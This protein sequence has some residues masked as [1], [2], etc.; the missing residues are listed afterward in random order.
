M[1]K[2]KLQI[3]AA[4]AFVCL[5]WGTSWMATRVGLDTL[6]PFVS[7]G[8]RFIVAALVIWIIMKFKNIKL[9]TDKTSLI[10]YSILI[11]FSFVLPSGL[12]YWGQQFIPS[13][14]ASVLFSTYPFFTAIFAG[15]FLSE[16]KIRTG[17]I[18]SMVISFTGIVVIFSNDI[19]A[20]FNLNILA[21]LA[22]FISGVLQAGIAVTM[23]KYG[24]NL[25]PLSMNFIPMLVSGIILLVGGLILEDTSNL[26][27]S[28]AAVSSIIFLAIFASVISYTAYFWM[29]KKISVVILSLTAFITPIVALG[30]GVFFLGEKLSNMQIAGSIL[31][32]CGI[33]FANLGSSF[34]LIIKKRFAGRTI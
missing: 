34:Y 20:N 31:V 8:L 2:V 19:T 22:V 21:M 33:L 14:L 23:K 17:Q 26:S 10:L 13:G 32:L 1:N 18:I 27:F 7:S 15:L 24:N 11:I 12:T 6:K 3:I 28:T 16:E 5:I 25:N 30:A 29:L 9:Q 4:Y